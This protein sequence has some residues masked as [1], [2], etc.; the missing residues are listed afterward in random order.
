MEAAALRDPYMTSRDGEQR[1]EFRC[2]RQ[3]DMDDTDVK[4]E[5]R[6]SRGSNKHVSCTAVPSKDVGEDDTAGDGTIHRSASVK[7]SERELG[8]NPIA[9]LIDTQL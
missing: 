4:R 2:E 1:R 9:R 3:D 7:A 5:V 6:Y 8:V